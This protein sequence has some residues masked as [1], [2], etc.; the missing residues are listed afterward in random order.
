MP[1]PVDVSRH[2]ADARSGKLTSGSYTVGA[3]KTEINIP[4]WAIGFRLYP[5]TNDIRFAVGEDPVQA[6]S[7]A[8]AVGATAKADQFCTRLLEAGAQGLAAGLRLLRVS[9][10]AV[11]LVEFF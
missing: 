6:G 4:S 2:P 5:V 7:A 11:T 1:R 8:Q 10:D 9:A 3:T